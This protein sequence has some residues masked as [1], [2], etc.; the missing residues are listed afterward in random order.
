MQGKYFII[1]YGCQMNKADS[2]RI[3]VALERKGYKEAPKKDGADL[4]LVNMCSV[5]Q[6]AVDRVYGLLHKFKTLK[7]KKPKLK[8]ILTGCILKKDRQKFAKGFDQILK[9]KD[10]LKYSPTRAAT[11]GKE[12]DFSSL[13]KYREKSMAFVP[14]SNGCNNFCSYCVVPF[15]RGPLVCRD[16]KEILKEVE[17]AVKNGFKEIW[18]LGQNVNDYQSPTRAAA[19]GEEEDIS[20]S[21]TNPKINFAK[22]LKMTDDIP[23]D[24]KILFTSPHPSNFSDELID[25]L[26]NC[27]KFGKYINLPVQSGDDKILRKMNRNY[28]VKEYKNLVKKIRAKITP[29][30]LSTDAIV[31]FPGETKKQFRNTVKLFKK[32]KFDWAYISKYSPRSGTAAFKMKDSVPL[33]EKKKREKILREIIQQYAEKPNDIKPGV[34]PLKKL[35]VILGPTA[36]GKSELAVRLAKKFNGE[37]ISADSRQ[38]YKGMD[39]G[40]GKITKK[41]MQNISHYLLDVASPKRRFTVVQYKKLAIKTINKIFKKGKIPILCGGTGFYIQAVLDGIVIPEVK[42]DWRL[43][44]NLEQLS[45]DEL[46]NRLKKLDPKRAKTIDKNNR[47]R[48]IRALEIVI[49]TKKPVPV[50]KKNP[51]PYPVLM[52]GIKKEKEELKKLINKR[53]LR[54]LKGEG[55]IEEVKKLRKAGIF[56]KRLE[57]FGLEYR[58]IAQYLQKKL[59]YDEMINL[60]QKEIEH[61][62]KRQL[63]WFKKDDRIHWFKNYKKAEKLTKAFLEK[64]RRGN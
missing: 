29:V 4:I 30:K 57:E 55:M 46:F 13:T 50:S 45:T 2:E 25:T 20:S 21:P 31:G 14:I 35:I 9:F 36:S 64:I 17:N 5:R 16:H 15:V 19:K 53:L 41:E 33:I 32:N 28:S 42:P 47:R 51:L 10:L 48:L 24:F 40:T 56:W 26:V 18:L 52:L 3:A 12:K 1:T 38:V 59:E 27:K 60:L 39:I 49:K 54:R 34:S 37:V 62:A 58:F 6:S 22:L 7:N 23:G 43:R 44:S 61:F 63:T 8:T 11:K